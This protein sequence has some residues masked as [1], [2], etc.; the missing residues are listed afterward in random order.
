MS[1]TLDARLLEIMQ[2]AQ[3]LDEY[4]RGSRYRNHFVT[5][6]GSDDWNHCTALVGLGFMEDHGMRPLYGT[7]QHCFTVTEAGDAVV[8]E[9]SPRPPKLTASQRRYKRYL[10]ADCGMSFIDWLRYTAEWNRENTRN[11]EFA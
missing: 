3:G 6:P 7:G 1:E 10:E 11:S 2:H 8:R 5:G 9:Q 4:G